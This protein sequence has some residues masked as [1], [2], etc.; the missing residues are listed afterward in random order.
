MKLASEIGRRM[1]WKPAASVLV[2]STM[3]SVTACNNDFTLGFAYATS[4]NTSSGLINAYAIDDQTGALKLLADSPI[5]TE[6]RKPEALVAAPNHLFLYVMN[7]DDSTVVKVGIG[8]DGKLYPQETYNITGSFPTAAAITADGKFLYVTYTYQICLSGTV[9]QNGTNPNCVAPLNGFTTASP[10][11]G[12]VTIF[13][14][15]S[16]NTLGTAIDFPIG[17]T[18]VGITTSAENNF[19]YVISQDTAATSS[20]SGQTGNLFAFSQNAST[21]ALTP[22]AGETINSAT[23]NVSSTGFPAGVLPAGVMEDATASHLYVSDFT[24]DVI[25]TYSI[26]STGVPTQLGSVATDVGPEGMTID[27]TGTYLYIANYT[28]GTLGG[29]TFGSNGTLT[30]LPA[31]QST[32]VGTGTTCVAVEPKKGV[33]LYTSN[34]LSNNVTGEELLPADGSLKPIIHSPYEASALPTCI[35]TVPRITFR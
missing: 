1:G 10:G 28:A 26:G 18:P 22:L 14:I 20:V 33:Y 34:S 21:G 19:V 3:L 17:K 9:G 4:A 23:G 11:P 16:D 8:T 29:Y 12:G 24:G 35:I 31:S 7:H 27:P 25:Y 30:A 2:L 15:N 13:P 5:P 6:G 32:E